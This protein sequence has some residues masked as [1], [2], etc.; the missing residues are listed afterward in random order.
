L[1]VEGPGF[2]G[3]FLLS[4]SFG[5]SHEPPIQRAPDE[6]L[7]EAGIERGEIIAREKVGA[8]RARHGL[9]SFCSKQ[10]A[11]TSPTMTH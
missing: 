4:Y 5:M 10:A 6:E 8:M 11:G 1:N 2:A 9:K 3:A 7:A